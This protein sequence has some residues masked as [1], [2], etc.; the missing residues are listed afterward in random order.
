MIEYSFVSFCLDTAIVLQMENFVICVTAIIVQTTLETKRKD[1]EPSNLVWSE[2]RTHLD[3]K[4]VKEKIPGKIS[5]DT[6][7]GAIVSAVGV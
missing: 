5:E 7:R 1:N 3:R 4:L 2:I 6:T